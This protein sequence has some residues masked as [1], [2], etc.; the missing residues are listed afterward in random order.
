M[1]FGLSFGFFIRSKLCRSKFT[2]FVLFVLGVKHGLH[3]N[4]EVRKLTQAPVFANQQQQ[5]PAL[6]NNTSKKSLKKDP[7]PDLVQ[8][9]NP[10]VDN[11]PSNPVV[12]Q[13]VPGADMKKRELNADVVQAAQINPTKMKNLHNPVQVEDD[14]PAKQ[15]AEIAPG[16]LVPNSQNIG[17]NNP[18]QVQ[19]DSQ[20]KQEAEIA[21]E[22]HITNPQ[23][24]GN[25]NKAIQISQADSKGPS[26]S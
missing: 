18:A 1:K 25:E 14:S 4:D 12:P 11:A 26:N 17:N 10:V 8:R 9:L 5:L 19:N 23:N 24:I 6:T 21:P 15:E 7:K 13:N 20:A 2:V 22:P 3:D 16:P